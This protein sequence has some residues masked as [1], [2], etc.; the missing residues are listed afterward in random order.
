MSETKMEH[1][2]ANSDMAVSS[3][4]H[5]PVKEK[6]LFPRLTAVI[7]LVALIIWGIYAA[8]QLL[9]LK[10]GFSW[11]V[12][13]F[14]KEKND[15]VDVVIIGS[16]HSYRGFIPMK[17]WVDLGYSAY[18]LSTANQPY[19]GS[20]YLMK[21]AIATQHPKVIIFEPYSARR[22]KKYG[23]EEPASMHRVTDFA[24]LNL[25]KISF[26]W[27][28]LR[29]DYDLED[30]LTYLFPLLSYHGRWNN[31]H[32]NDLYTSVNVTSHKGGIPEVAHAPQKAPA[33]YKPGAMS[34]ISSFYLQK[35]IDLCKDNNV[36]LIGIPTPIADIRSFGEIEGSIKDAIQMLRDEGMEGVM[37]EEILSETGI[38]Y[39]TDFYN[40]T[41][42]NLLGAEK[43]TDY[44]EKYLVEHADLTDHRGDPRY[45]SWEKAEP[46]FQERF[47][48]LKE[49]CLAGIRKDQES[50]K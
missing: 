40:A 16:S 46:V 19:I 27:T 22:K 39:E 25:H 13:D 30:S 38:D 11:N 36:Q 37:P 33:A 9:T 29:H 47:K 45:A 31:L 34:E 48:I 23:A 21:E 24:L 41:H 3:E 43:M 35:M 12:R 44:L 8:S 17:L 18:N 28:D 42:I 2:P 26:W 4:N 6:K 5:S 14:Y 20:Y 1:R 32:R 10:E 50:E 15:T 49:K 7:C